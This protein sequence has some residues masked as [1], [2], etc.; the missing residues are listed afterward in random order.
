[1]IET[2]RHLRLRRCLFV[3]AYYYGF[4]FVS[5]VAG[6]AGE[7]QVGA[8]YPNDF[9]MDFNAGYVDFISVACGVLCADAANDGELH[10]KI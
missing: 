9:T 5:D 6:K 2:K 3:W 1:M 8:E 4:S 7:I 10:G